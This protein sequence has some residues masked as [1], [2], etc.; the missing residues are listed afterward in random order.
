MD[1]SK[2]VTSGGIGGS[3]DYIRHYG[4]IVFDEDGS[5]VLWIYEILICDIWN[6]LDV[7]N[8]A[9]RLPS[10][11]GRD[12]LNL[13]DVNINASKSIFQMAPALQPGLIRI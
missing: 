7:T 3:L 6:G 5:L 13:C 2:K 9:Y 10:L 1:W 11:L 4:G 12:F 8:T